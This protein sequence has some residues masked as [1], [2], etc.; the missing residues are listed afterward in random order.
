MIVLC[1]DTA[2]ENIACALGRVSGS[3]EVEEVIASCD[4]PAPR[5]ANTQLVPRIMEMCEANSMKPEDMSLIV[6]GRGPGS[7]TGTRIAVA[8]A[9]G[10][11]TGLGIP[12]HGVST[13]DA[14][15][16]QVHSSG[17]RGLL[18]VVDDAMRGEVYPVRFRLTDAGVERLDPDS[19]A[20]PRDAAT[21]WASIT[22]EHLLLAGNGLT[23]HARAF[24]EAFSS[25]EPGLL[26]IS[27]KH[28]WLP[29]GAGLL[30]AYADAVRTGMLDYGAPALLLPVYTR[31]ADAEENERRNTGPGFALPKSGVD[32][33]TAAGGI[34]TR[35]MRATDIAEVAELQMQCFIGDAADDA[36]TEGMLTDDIARPD[37]VWWVALEHGDIIGAAGGWVVDGD[38]QILDVVTGPKARRKGIAR[39]L[40]VHLGDDGYAL[41]ASTASLEVRDGNEPA[42]KLYGRMGFEEIGRRRRYYPNGT[43]AIILSA[44]LPFDDRST[45]APH[46][47]VGGMELRDSVTAGASSPR[48]RPLIL[49]IETSCDETAAAVIDGGQNLAS[50]LIASQIDFHARFGGVVPE[51]ASRKHIEAIVDVCDEAMAQAGRSFGDTGFT[52]RDLDAVAVTTRPGLVGALVVGLAFAKGLSFAISKPLI[53]VNHLE[54]HLFA[55]LLITPDIEPPIV[56]LLVSGGHTM[57]VHVRS[58]GDYETLGSTLDDAVGEAFDKVAKALGLGYPGGPVISRLAETGDPGAIDFPRAMLHSGDFR[59]SLSGLKTAVVT[60]INQQMDAGAR[61][62]VH[63]LAASF[64]QAVVD[65]L[66]A[67]TRTALET[68]GAREFCLGGGV[69]ANPALRDELKRRI[70]EMGVRVTLPPLSAC[71]DNAGMIAVA[72]LRHYEMGRFADLHIDIKAHAPLDDEHTVNRV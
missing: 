72:A 71:T 59:F 65:V 62:D 9:K 37:R 66:V 3:G 38:M 13:L 25:M 41:G 10:I 52:Y 16:W 7:F 56:A 67:K 57:L 42:L 12:V 50:D 2:T 63:D 8:T 64:Q 36:W 20:K 53:D 51:I 21:R 4:V 22:D 30:S 68:T 39:R 1:M 70:E 29:T 31:L 27:D 33:A 18:G 28:L 26:E 34:I 14:I 44:R 55:N 24:L 61:I 15:A 48:A 60:Y 23:K 5:A 49:A 32:D 69:A 45:D 19:V 58:W 40:L 46:G 17:I 47:N 54:G 43:D 35:P 6:C 11:A